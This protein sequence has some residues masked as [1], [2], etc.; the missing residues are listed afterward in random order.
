MVYVIGCHLTEFNR[1]KDGSSYRDWVCETFEASLAMS[2]LE[3][4]DIDTLIISNESDFFTFQ[5][6]PS[7]VIAD[8]LGLHK[9]EIVR[10][11]GGGASG[12]LAVHQGVKS[13]LSK[14]SQYVAIIGFDPS[15]SY[16]PSETVKQLYSNSFDSLTDGMNGVT[17]TALYAL[18]IQLFMKKTGL[19]ETDLANAT[20]NNR[21][22]ALHNPGAHLKLKHNQQEIFASPV[23]SS[24]YRRLH[25]SPLSDGAASLILSNKK[26]LNR[27]SAPNIIGI[28]SANDMVNLGA[29]DD[30]GEFVSKKEAMKKASSMAGIRAN[31]IGFA[32]VY[33]AYAGAQFQA[34]KALG[35]SSDFLKDFRDGH[36]SLD[37]KLPINISGGL[38]GQG[39][40]VG[41]TG[42]G[43]TA[44]CAM[45]F[46]GKYHKN[47]QIKNIPKFALAD[48]H[49]GVGTL[50]AV[51]ILKSNI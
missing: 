23:I 28:G 21:N 17:A 35:L 37:G 26:P 16:L 33:D 29:R 2:S 51:S 22:N 43:Q 49:G 9:V 3:R 36:F 50:S 41:A 1:R 27:I 39:A 12:Q 7:T 25:C 19:N 38:M 32:E 4:K 46:E 44:T 30:I 18:S 15:A 10:V 6:N 5:L 47:L 8:D 13:I 45:V 20:I 34:I 48:T 42:V 14:K 11:E 40:P 31:E 24:P